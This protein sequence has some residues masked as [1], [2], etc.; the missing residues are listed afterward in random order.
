MR[1]LAQRVRRAEVRLPARISGASPAGGGEVVG[2]I[3][4]G[5]VVLVGVGVDDTLEDARLLATR[6]A[7][8]RIF[9]DEAGRLNRSILDVSGDV[10]SIPQF[11]LY[12]ETRGGRR[13][14]FIRAA[15]PDRA[16]PLYLEFNRA[17]EALGIRVVPGRFRTHMVV[18]IH[19]D[20]PVTL[21]LDSRDR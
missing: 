19:N 17:L 21:L 11:T 10:L 3:G 13:P 9:D 5:M 20:G 14:S 18:E 12:A 4:A 15:P 7:H 6:L 16:E 2:Q 1:A 8:L